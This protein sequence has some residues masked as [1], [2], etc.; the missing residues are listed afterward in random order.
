MS[1]YLDV[2]AALRESRGPAVSTEAREAARRLNTETGVT[3]LIS[4]IIANAR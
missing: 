2:Y 1:T 4:S 3:A